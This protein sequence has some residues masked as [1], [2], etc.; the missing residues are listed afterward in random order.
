MY[1]YSEN[2]Q[3]IPGKKTI[4]LSLT[5]TRTWQ[6]TLSTNQKHGSH[7]LP[8]ELICISKIKNQKYLF[9]MESQNIPDN[10]SLPHT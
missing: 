6:D 4:A 3:N 1:K 10:Y 5:S 9:I 7:K 8:S 2:S